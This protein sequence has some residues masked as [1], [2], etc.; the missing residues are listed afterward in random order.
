MII[1]FL[2]TRDVPLLPSLQNIW[3]RQQVSEVPKREVDGY[4]AY[5]FEDLADLGR[6][7]SSKNTE[8]LGELLVGFF[9]YYATDF[10]YI[11]GI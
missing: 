3:D 9:R 11:T 4:N 6:Y 2:Q 5:F 7:W 1:H 8:S 10:P